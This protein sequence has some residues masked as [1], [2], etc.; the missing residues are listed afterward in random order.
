[1]PKVTFQFSYFAI[2]SWYISNSIIAKSI[3]IFV[4]R[5]DE[6]AICIVY[7]EFNNISLLPKCFRTCLGSSGLL[8]LLGI[9]CL[10]TLSVI[11]YTPHVSS[12]VRFLVRPSNLNS[13]V[14]D[15]SSIRLIVIGSNSFFS[16]SACFSA[17]NW[18]STASAS[19]NVGKLRNYQLFPTNCFVSDQYEIPY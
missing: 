8:V 2:N 14:S 10:T 3:L 19:Y 18:L 7:I 16:S 6:V 11:K 17:D 12:G 5:E 9:P 15:C 13:W 4:F 1:M